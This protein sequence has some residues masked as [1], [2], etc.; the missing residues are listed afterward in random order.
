MVLGAADPAEARRRPARRAPPPARVQAE[1]RESKVV[2]LRQRGIAAYEDA[3]RAFR[4]LTPSRVVEVM[5][6]SDPAEPAVREEVTDE[7]PDLVIALGRLAMQVLRPGLGAT[8][9]VA[10]F[11]PG[12]P[13]TAAPRGGYLTSGPPSTLVL[14][15]M[16][17]LVPR[18]R[19]AGVVTR[20]AP[21]P[22]DAEF[23]AACRRLGVSPVV[24]TAASDADVARALVELV[25]QG[26]EVI[27]LGRDPRLL[28]LR[29]LRQ[30]VAVQARFRRP[31]IGV[32]LEHA[33]YGLA[34]AIDSSPEEIGAG[35]KALIDANAAAW[36]GTPRAGAGG[37]GGAPVRGAGAAPD[38]AQLVRG[39]A[40]A[41]R[42]AYNPGSLRALGREAAPLE[43]AGARP[44]SAGDAP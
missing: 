38:G 2:I 26:A 1:A 44:V 21:D 27:W 30:A 43:K 31:L 15:W 6:S 36:L 28:P 5:V 29:A 3:A 17:R 11:L 34:L 35:L 32:T 23:R 24:A 20:G 4:R 33:R 40:R 18:L 37:R 10:A 16:K 8:P 7:K 14:E 19:R 39:V 41:T 25:R 9:V 12:P 22:L 13:A 42:A